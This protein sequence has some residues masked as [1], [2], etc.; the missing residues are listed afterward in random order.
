MRSIYVGGHGNP[1]LQVVLWG[2]NFGRILV[3]ASAVTGFRSI[4]ILSYN[5]YNIKHNNYIVYSSL[6]QEKGELFTL[7]L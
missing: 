3:I 4:I 1:P 7:S 2:I 5:V 6:L